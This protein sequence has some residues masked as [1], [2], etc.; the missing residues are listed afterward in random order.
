[1]QVRYRIFPALT[2]SVRA[3]EIEFQ[4]VRP[5]LHRHLRQRLP[6]ALVQRAHD[7]GHDHTVGKV[8]LELTD[9]PGK[10]KRGTQFCIQRNKIKYD[11][12]CP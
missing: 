11:P 10:G 4:R 12:G 2:H 5:R 7:G 6:V 3:A 1:M 8:G 9:A